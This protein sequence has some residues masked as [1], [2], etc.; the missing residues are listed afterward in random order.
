MAGHGGKRRPSSPCSC[1][2]PSPCPF[3]SCPFVHEPPSAGILNQFA[4]SGQG[5][6]AVDGQNMDMRMEMLG[7]GWGWEWG[8]A[9]LESCQ[10]PYRHL[11]C[12]SQRSPGHQP[13]PR[14]IPAPPHTNWAPPH[15]DSFLPEEETCT[16]AP[17]V[18]CVGSLKYHSGSVVAPGHP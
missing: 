16:Q 7:W 12:S 15:F 18:R 3:T 10:R 6:A 4:V 8:T 11:H 9:A 17:M 13:Q 2:C 1:D 5:N 14:P